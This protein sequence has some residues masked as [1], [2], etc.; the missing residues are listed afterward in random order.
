MERC[1]QAV[2]RVPSLDG[3]TRERF[4]R[5]VYPRVRTRAR[6]ERGAGAAAGVPAKPSQ[7]AGVVQPS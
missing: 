2:V 6:R 7:A 5:D 3:V 1:E 4:L